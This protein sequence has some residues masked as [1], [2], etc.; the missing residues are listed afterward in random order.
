MYFCHMNFFYTNFCLEPA[1]ATAVAA[2]AAAAAN[3]TVAAVNATVT[4]AA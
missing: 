4:A 2:V 3:A 1:A